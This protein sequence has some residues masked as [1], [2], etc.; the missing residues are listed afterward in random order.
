VP[1]GLALSRR[2]L[3]AGA[4]ALAGAAAVDAFG[5][6]PQWLEVTVHDV[7]IAGLAH[8]L[9]G[10]TIAHF[11]DMH[12]GG[13]GRT[14]EKILATLKAHRAN[15]VVLTGD[16]IDSAKHFTALGDL[17]DAVRSL[18][19]PLLATLGNWENWGHI[20]SSELHRVYA[21]TGAR[22]VVNDSASIDGVPF[23]ATDD[24]YSGKP[25]WNAPAAAA[26]TAPRLL[27]THSPAILD[28][29][30]S[31]LPAFDFALSGHTHGGQVRAGTL[32]PVLPPGSGR[33]VAG[34]YDTPAGPAYVSRGTGMSILPVR[35]CCRPE[36]PIFRLV[37]G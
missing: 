27:L 11:T 14:E 29:F 37:R 15:A 3:L 12:L 32:A 1:G 9:E 10:F 28:H 33:F 19:M 34:H 13:I 16:A 35:F 4:G 6:E 30:P 36:L 5:I 21:R 31:G 8:S 2:K 20:D 24:G 18:G 26:T 25:R 7:P 23:Y 17:C 22:L